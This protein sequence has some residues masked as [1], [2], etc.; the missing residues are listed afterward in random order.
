MARMK[1]TRYSFAIVVLGA[2]T[3]EALVAG[4]G[5]GDERLIRAA[6]ARSN[7]AIATHDV[8]AIT[9]VW[10]D[11]VHVVSSTSAQTAGLGAN[12]Q[13]FVQQFKNR[14]DT[15]YVRTPASIEVY[16]AWNVAAERGEW[17]GRWTEPDGL[18]TIGGTYLAQWR[19]I[20]GEWLIQAEL[21]VPTHCRGSRYC[22]Q[23]P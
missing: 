4:Q 10:M 12:R 11:S 19:K 15:I 23:R 21:Y 13:R 3:L 17:T 8:P 1:T 14:P 18:L 9:S 20:D 16:P 6:R 7:A 5:P 2:L 22:R